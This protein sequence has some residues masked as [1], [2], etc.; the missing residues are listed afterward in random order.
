MIKTLPWW[1]WLIPLVR[2]TLTIGFVLFAG[3]LQGHASGTWPTLTEWCAA[4]RS[5]RFLTVPAARTPRA[6]SQMIALLVHNGQQIVG[7]TP[8]REPVLTA[9]NMH[10]RVGRL[11]CIQSHPS[12]IEIIVRLDAAAA[13]DAATGPTTS[14]TQV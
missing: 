4:M 14:D 7:S 12:Q 3:T 10:C 8:A 5:L 13:S 1:L 6:L 11:R 9:V 2:P